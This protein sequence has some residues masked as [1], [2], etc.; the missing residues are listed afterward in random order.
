[1]RHLIR[2]LL[3]VAAALG[4]SAAAGANSPTPA[5]PP[6][7]PGRMVRAQQ[8]YLAYCAMCH[9]PRGAG[10]GEVTRAL[11]RSN[12]VVPRLDDGVRLAKTGRAG[13]L[14]IVT[15]GGAHAGRSNVMPEWGGLVGERLAGDLADFVMSLPGNA[16]G[17]P[18]ATLESYLTAPAGVPAEGRATYVFRCSACHGPT[19][20]GDGPSGDLLW[21]K[22]GVR[23]RDLTDAHFM[24]GRTDRDLFAAISLGGA[25]LGR[26]AYMPA[27]DNDLSAT[28][29]KDLVAYLRQISK[30]PARP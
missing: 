6:A 27:W 21:R 7:P 11:R 5:K 16:G 10:D 2:A 30:T 19:G 25:H 14:R 4:L 8:A 18:A 1:M 26:S 17:V 13:V 29:I 24:R 20:R 9:G 15:Q 12:I 28:Q 23:P 22:H 3:T